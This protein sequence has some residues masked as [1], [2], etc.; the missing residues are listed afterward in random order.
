METVVLRFLVQRLL[1][2]RL[3]EL[4]RALSAWGGRDDR[5][6]EGAGV[7]LWRS[8]R[9]ATAVE[10]AMIALPMV[11][12]LIG[13][14][15]IGMVFMVATALESATDV[16][17]RQIRIGALQTQTTTATAAT[18]KT[19]VC[20]HMS[21]LSGPC[22]SNL[23]VDVRTFT[24]FQVMALPNPVSSG[25]LLPQNQLQFSLGGPGSIVL[26]RTYYPWTLMAPMLDK[27][28][29]QTTNGQI[30]IS[31]TTTFRNEPYPSTP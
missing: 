19:V 8:E 24:Q 26:V 1:A 16:A 23:E 2:G 21:W 30:V 31:A 12:L 10:F 7:T 13:I 15:E 9:A 6:G 25:A 28:A 18:F 14:V 17:A 3:G 29:T 5:A 27:M 11:M 22:A 4:F 20:N